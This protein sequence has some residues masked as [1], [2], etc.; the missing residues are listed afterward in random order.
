M[1]P[2]LKPTRIPAG[3]RKAIDAP[4]Q[5]KIRNFRSGML[6]E[7]RKSTANGITSIPKAQKIKLK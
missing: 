4:D 7:T 3:P 6:F 5:S 1:P 2:Q